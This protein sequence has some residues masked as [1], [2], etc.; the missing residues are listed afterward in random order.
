MRRGEGSALS[1]EIRV[2]SVVE[3]AQLARRSQ[4]SPRINAVLGGP[5]FIPV[6]RRQ[7][8]GNSVAAAALLRHLLR[9]LLRKGLS[10]SWSRSLRAAPRRAAT[11]KALQQETTQASITALSVP[12][13]CPAR[14]STP[15]RPSERH[16]NA[17]ILA[18]P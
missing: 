8:V 18:A 7:P 9:H 11:S 17:A 16:V 5:T 13:R 6:G 14:S 3:S 15:S 10:C 4:E 1:A 12:E 2:C